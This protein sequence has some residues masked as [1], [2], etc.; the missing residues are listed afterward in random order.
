MARLF[1][2][3]SGSPQPLKLLPDGLV[4][5]GGGRDGAGACA[6]AR[7]GGETLRDGVAKLHARADAG[8]GKGA[9]GWGSHVQRRVPTWSG[10]W[11]VG[12]STLREPDD[13]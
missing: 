2:T 8:V 3:C 9:C 12:A 11:E 13:F 7:G 1:E 6:E 4:A 10:C 5:A